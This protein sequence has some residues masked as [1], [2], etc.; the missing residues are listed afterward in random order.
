M[1][2]FIGSIPDLAFHGYYEASAH[3]LAGFNIPS[4]NFIGDCDSKYLQ[5]Y[6]T[7]FPKPEFTPGKVAQSFYQSLFMKYVKL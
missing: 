5:Q 7:H 6:C 2:Q 3:E 1:I 4:R